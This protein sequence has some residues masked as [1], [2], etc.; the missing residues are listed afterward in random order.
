MQPITNQI[1]PREKRIYA[2]LQGGAW[3]LALACL[4]IFVSIDDQTW[5]KVALVGLIGFLLAAVV[6]NYGRRFG[7]RVLWSKRLRDR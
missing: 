5:K 2:V 4:A 1:S 3:L 7:I 6:F